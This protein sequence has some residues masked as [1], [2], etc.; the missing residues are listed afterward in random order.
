MK[1]D[2]SLGPRIVV[3]EYIQG[4]NIWRFPNVSLRAAGVQLVLDT[5]S[6]STFTVKDRQNEAHKHTAP[7][8]CSKNV[9][10]PKQ[11]PN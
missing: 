5:Y 1:G 2:I 4:G 8:Y 6:Y 9:R 3:P 11:G 10:F 7:T